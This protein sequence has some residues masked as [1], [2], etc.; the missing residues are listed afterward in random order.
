MTT[1]NL[2][3]TA[4]A[5]LLVF[6]TTFVA[7]SVQA[8]VDVKPRVTAKGMFYK[9]KTQAQTS[10][11]GR[12]ALKAAAKY[13]AAYGQWGAAKGKSMSCKKIVKSS[14]S[15]L[16]NCKASAKPAKKF[17]LCKG[18]VNA[19]G[20]QYKKGAKALSSAH[21][22]WGLKAAA[23]YGAPYGFWNKSVKRGAKC[24]RN[25]NGLVQCKVTAKACR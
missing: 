1:F 4:Q 12:W 11:Q 15:K 25:P 22:R 20:M 13:G 16:W 14:G 21:G 23:K 3:T 10:A 8:A 2:K 6:A 18:R 19:Q 7:T 5:A 9:N 24:K 17:K